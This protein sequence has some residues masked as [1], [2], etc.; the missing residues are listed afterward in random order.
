[1]FG[2]HG[3][4]S[5]ETCSACASR[6][7]VRALVVLLR[8]APGRDGSRE[9]GPAKP[10]RR[11]GGRKGESR[12]DRI[13]T[14][15]RRKCTNAYHLPP[16]TPL[17]SAD[18]MRFVQ[19]ETLAHAKSRG[20]SPPCIASSAGV[21]AHTLAAAWTK[22][23]ANKGVAGVDA[24]YDALHGGDLPEPATHAYLKHRRR[25]G[26]SARPAPAAT[27]TASSSP[28]RVS[29][30]ASVSSTSFRRGRPGPWSAAASIAR[31]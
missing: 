6:A 17:P 15:E 31:A 25:R 12:D 7:G 19:T 22:V 11:E 24:E 26:R 1:M 27:A 23:R 29:T 4:V 30:I 16:L 9:D 28:D 5:G 13:G 20:A 18:S 10:R 21:R 14:T 2:R 3:R 8:P